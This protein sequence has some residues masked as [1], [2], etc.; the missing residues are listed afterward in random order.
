[1]TARRRFCGACMNP[2]GIVQDGSLIEVGPPGRMFNTTRPEPEVKAVCPGIAAG[3]HDVRS[4]VRV[5]VDG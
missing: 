2:Y 1:M 4:L 3:T 5:E